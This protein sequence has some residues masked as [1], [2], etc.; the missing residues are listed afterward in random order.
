MLRPTS[1][2]FQFQIGLKDF[3]ARIIKMRAGTPPRNPG[4][5]AAPTPPATARAKPLRTTANI[6]PMIARIEVAA[7]KGVCQ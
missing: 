6:P 2:L 7:K 3:L 1:F 4:L 5:R